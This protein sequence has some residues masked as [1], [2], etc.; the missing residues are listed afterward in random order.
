MCWWLMITLVT[1]VVSESVQCSKGFELKQQNLIACLS[2]C[3]KPTTLF[4]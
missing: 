4:A 2:V 1:K 3:R